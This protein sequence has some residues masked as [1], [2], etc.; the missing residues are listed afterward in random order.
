MIHYRMTLNEHI[1]ARGS[2]VDPQ[3]YQ[4]SCQ[5]YRP[6]MLCRTGDGHAIGTRTKGSVTC[7]KCLVALQ[8]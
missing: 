1:S 6:E 3:R 4:S 5:D 7:D 2:Y 8:K